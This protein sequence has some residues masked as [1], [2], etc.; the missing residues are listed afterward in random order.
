MKR[1]C[2]FFN[3]GDQISLEQPKKEWMHLPEKNSYKIS[4]HKLWN[5]T[6]SLESIWQGALLLKNITNHSN[7]IFAFP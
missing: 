1:F 4:A 3:L 5:H 7:C 2:C 6:D